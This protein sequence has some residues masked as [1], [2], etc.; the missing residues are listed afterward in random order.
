MSRGSN[1]YSHPTQRARL[2]HPRLR[3]R[4]VCPCCHLDKEAGLLI[5][6]PCF[7]LHDM[8]NGNPEVEAKL[9]DMEQELEL[10]TAERDGT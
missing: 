1:Q 2:D 3:A 5:C 9:D 7:N 10:E 6:W 8:R 4:T